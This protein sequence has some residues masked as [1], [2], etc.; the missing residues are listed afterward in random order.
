MNGSIGVSYSTSLYEIIGTL[1]A[2]IILGVILLIYGNKKGVRKVG[3]L[4]LGACVASSFILGLYVQIPVFI[5]FLFLIKVS[6]RKQII[7]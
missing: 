7:T 4:G 1:L 5:I 2:G 6:S 3:F